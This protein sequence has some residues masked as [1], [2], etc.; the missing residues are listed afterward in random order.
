MDL[1]IVFVF[2]V[3]I[4]GGS[5]VVFSKNNKRTIAKGREQIL[6]VWDKVQGDDKVDPELKQ[7]VE[8]AKNTL[9]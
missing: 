8:E 6:A 5:V 2:G 7:R 9:E 3:V 1:L 4:G